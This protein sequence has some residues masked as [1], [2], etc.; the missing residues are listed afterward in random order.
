VAVDGA[1]AVGSVGRLLC[2]RACLGEE[3]M[4]VGAVVAVRG[5]SK[6]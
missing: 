1:E 3:E 4:V 6:D 5:R 2:F